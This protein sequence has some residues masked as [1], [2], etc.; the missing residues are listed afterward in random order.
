MKRVLATLAL[1]SLAATAFAGGR[2]DGIYASPLSNASWVSLHHDDVRVVAA[3]FNSTFRMDGTVII[4]TTI[5]TTIP[6]I[7]NTWDLLGGP[8]SGNVASISGE[9]NYG[10]CYVTMR[11]V[12]A[13]GSF[14]V[15]PVSS[16]QTAQGRRTNVSCQNAF[17]GANWPLTFKR[18][19]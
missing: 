11:L 3:S 17:Q 2:Y 18:I 12:L 14:Q 5:G 6:S 15:F 10:T 13:D 16:V 9:F 7:M 4:T 8:L 19:F 1:I